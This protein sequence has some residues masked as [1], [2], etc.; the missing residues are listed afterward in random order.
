MR[1]I[2]NRKDTVLQHAVSERNTVDR[3][4]VMVGVISFVAVMVSRLSMQASQQIEENIQQYGLSASI[5]DPTLMQLAVRIGITLAIIISTA[6]QILYLYLCVD[7]DEKILNSLIL[8][9]GKVSSREK[10]TGLGMAT[11]SGLLVT[12]PVQVAA[13]VLNQTSPKNSIWFYAWIVTVVITM[14]MFSWNRISAGKN[15]TKSR[16]SVMAI[17]FCIVAISI[18]L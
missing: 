15:N 12:V 13:L 17:L 16:I 18:L 1:S 6:F 10:Y 5:S 11:L 7:V 2:L 14:T 4:I 9:I 3:R 8:P